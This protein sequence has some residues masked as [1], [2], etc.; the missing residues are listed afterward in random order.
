MGTSNWQNI[1]FCI[2]TLM[3]IQ[4]QRVL[5][6]GVGFGRWG[7]IVREFCDVWYDHV[8]PND[9]QIHIEGIEGFAD[10][11]DDYHKHFYNKIHIGDARRI[12]PTLSTTWDVIIFGDVLEHFERQEAEQLLEWALDNSTYVLI[13]IPLGSEWPQE[14]KYKNPY[15]RHLSEWEAQDFVQFS[16]RRQAFFYDFMDRKFGSFILSHDDPQELSVSLFSR[17]T[18]QSGLTIQTYE[19]TTHQDDIEAQIIDRV[20]VMRSELQVVKQ[21]LHE[22]QRSRSF[23]IMNRVRRSRYGQWV[24]KALRIVIPERDGLLRAIVH[25]DPGAVVRPIKR[26]IVPIYM[27]LSR[28]HVRLC[29]VAKRNS[30]SKGQEIWLLAIN[31]PNT[32][33]S[34]LQ[35]GQRFG[36]WDIQANEFTPTGKCLLHKGHGKGLA[37]FPATSGTS[38]TFMSHPWS[39]T[40]DITWR[41]QTLR[42]DLYTA[43]TGTI[44]VHLPTKGKPFISSNPALSQNQGG[45]G[46]VVTPHLSK[47][48]ARFTATEKAWIEKQI[49]NPQPI[50]VLH[51]DWRGIRSSANQLFDELYEVN[52][53]LDE[54]SALHYAHLFA[55]TNCPALVI[56][57]FP[58]SYRH[59]VQA[60]HRIVPNIPIYVIWHGNFLQTGEDYA[61]EGFRTVAQLCQNQAITKWG[62]VK[63]G[64]AEVMQSRGFR[65]G[66]VMNL[67]RTIPERPSTPLNDGLHVGVWG[68]PYNWRKPPYAMLGSIAL[69]ENPIVHT[70]NVDMRTQEFARFLELP[71]QFDKQAI[72]QQQMP[73]VLSQ[74]HLN[75]YVTLSE[76]APMLPLESLS[77]GVPCLL[78]ATS[79][80]FEDHEYLY[81]RL[82]VPHADSA[83]AIANSALR[84]LEERDA[85]V[86]AYRDYAPDYNSRALRCLEEFLEM[87]CA[88]KA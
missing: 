64:M 57:G 73:R 84:V 4:P 79:H 5:D 77:V 30:N 28:N 24:K 82:V 8:L 86:E 32:V 16:L 67:V 20:R 12:I 65:T 18:A 74:M 61:W 40:I 3:K 87:P 52:D 50:A 68:V 15:E 27:P 62:F 46:R 23:R 26:R 81:S 34:D 55:E 37:D 31:S 9:W 11:I 83:Q 49:R 47:Q 48:T 21:Q 60:L 59:L 66:F 22:I 88:V 13:N 58:L 45:N 43:E 76:C 56:Q 53:T 51:P 78:G 85:I 39:D 35:R 80:Y 44:H 69:L 17:S 14:D 6:I 63:R 75:M 54:R 71:G 42:L 41:G 2:D 19:P 1:P 10:N 72:S 25:R 7:M 36:H 29:T 33:S 70:S 38:L